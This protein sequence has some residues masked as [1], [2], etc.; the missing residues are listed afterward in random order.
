MIVCNSES[1]RSSDRRDTKRG[2]SQMQRL[3]Q[4]FA[5]QP[6]GCQPPLPEQHLAYMPG[7]PH[8]A[9]LNLRRWLGKKVA[10]CK[11]R[12]WAA[13]AA[14]RASSARGRRRLLHR[15]SRIHFRASFGGW[16][17]PPGSSQP[18]WSARLPGRCAARGGAGWRPANRSGMIFVHRRQSHV[19]LNPPASKSGRPS[20]PTPCWSLSS[21]R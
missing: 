15:R 14:R 4:E 13:S 2:A 16:R 20:L 12:L 6:I 17:D 7:P 1:A 8:L 21:P 18:R 5:S 9:K 19:R 11:R 10:K 3:S